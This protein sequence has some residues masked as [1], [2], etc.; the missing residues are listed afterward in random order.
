[1]VHEVDVGLFQRVDGGGDLGDL[2]RGEGAPID[3]EPIRVE[4]VDL[5][6]RQRP[7]TG[8]PRVL[9]DEVP[10][11]GCGRG[12]ETGA[13]MAASILTPLSAAS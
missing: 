13:S 7:Q 4:G 11:Q 6:R 12:V 9:P 8:A 10:V 2:G 3:E 1:L 5:L